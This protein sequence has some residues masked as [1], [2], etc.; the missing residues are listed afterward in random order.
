MMRTGSERNLCWIGYGCNWEYLPEDCKRDVVGGG[1][2]TY[3]FSVTKRL[4]NISRTF[5]LIDSIEEGPDIQNMAPIRKNNKSIAYPVHGKSA[6]MLLAGGHVTSATKNKLESEYSIKAEDISL[7]PFDVSDAFR[8]DSRK[9]FFKY[10]RDASAIRMFEKLSSA[11]V[12]QEYVDMLT[13]GEAATESSRE[14]TV[15]MEEE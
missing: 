7:E 2:V 13:D 1:G 6:N 3:K 4:T 14:N 8:V 11:G 9:A 5:L 10:M 15:E 12:P